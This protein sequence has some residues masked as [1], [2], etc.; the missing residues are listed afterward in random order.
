MHKKEDYAISK[1][2]YDNIECYHPDGTL[3]CFLSARQAEWY[4]KK[5]LGH[6]F[7]EKPGEN[8]KLKLNFIPNGKGEPEVLLR[9]RKN[10]CVVSGVSERLTKHHVIPYQYRKCFPS[11]YKNRNHFDLVLL[12]DQVH[13]SYERDADVLKMLLYKDFVGGDI[14]QFQSDFTTAHKLLGKKKYYY[15]KLSPD[16]QVYLDMRFE[17]L[18]ERWNLKDSDFD[19]FDMVRSKSY[20]QKIIDGVI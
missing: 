4:L 19:S 8:K 13:H 3:M 20:T 17:G 14:I 12:N 10:I 1:H 5:D 18:K 2:P 15:D 16:K 6:Y 9:E 11:K 7:D